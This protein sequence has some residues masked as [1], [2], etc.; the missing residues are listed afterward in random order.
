[1]KQPGNFAGGTVGSR[2]VPAHSLA[3]SKAASPE[4]QPRIATS[5]SSLL[6]QPKEEQAQQEQVTLGDYLVKSLTAHSLDLPPQAAK[7]CLLAARHLGLLCCLHGIHQSY[8]QNLCGTV[9]M[10]GLPTSL[11]ASRVLE[12][13]PCSNNPTSVILLYWLGAVA[14]AAA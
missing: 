11:K 13:L 12:P 9:G 5:K 2:T 6:A 8:I 14:A 4:A 7:V 1:M 10:L 3:D